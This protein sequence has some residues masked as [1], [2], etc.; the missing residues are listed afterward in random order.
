MEKQ[1]EEF[2]CI[3]KNHFWF[4]SSLNFFT[5]SKIKFKNEAYKCFL[6]FIIYSFNKYLF[7]T[8]DK[9]LG[10][11]SWNLNSTKSCLPPD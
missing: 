8:S 7:R 1:K 5:N 10:L 2:H 6:N 4:Y 3:F 11:T 9:I